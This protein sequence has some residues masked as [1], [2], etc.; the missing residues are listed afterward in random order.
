MCFLFSHKCSP[1][2]CR[3]YLNKSPEDPDEDLPGL[4]EDTIP[5]LDSILLRRSTVAT[6]V[7]RRMQNEQDSSP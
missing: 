1:F 4:E 5:D 7:E 3:R 2:P 6:A